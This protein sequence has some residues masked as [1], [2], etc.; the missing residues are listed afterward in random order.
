MYETSNS[1]RS[2]APLSP[3]K[4]PAKKPVLV[5]ASCIGL[6][7]ADAA[8]AQ[9]QVQIYGLMDL[10]YTR[11]SNQG[12]QSV[13]KI[14]SG[15]LQGSR[16]GFRGTEELGGGNQAFFVLEAGFNADNGTLLA[17]NVLF[18]RDSRVGLSGPWGS[19]AA[20]RQSPAMVDYIWRFSSVG[21][22][23]GP[24]LFST[25]PGNYDR[26]LNLAGD[27]SVK[28]ST[29]NLAGFTGSAQYF[30][31]EQAAGSPSL[32]GVSAGAGYEN[33]P[34]AVGGGYFKQ[35]GPI[36]VTAFLAPAANPFT[37]SNPT[38]SLTSYALGASYAIGPAVIHVLATQAKF[39]TAANKARTYEVGGKLAPAGTAWTFGA[40][41]STTD[42]TN[43][44][45]RLNLLTVSASYALSKRTDLYSIFS[46]EKVSGTNVGGTPLVA[47]IFTQG[48]SSSGSQN[49]FQL[50]IRHKF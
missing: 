34:F 6:L 1:I 41:Y 12:G 32:K 25:H 39:E 19:V 18:S 21:A 10:G 26:S 28:Y 3:G 49:A 7:A 17:P 40:D 30:F 15:Q 36:S 23:Y 13:S 22:V 33:G 35:N 2:F 14:S 29:P 27:N 50:G 5:L 38:D 43:R 48:A 45:A 42:V 20:G 31:G 4:K 47:Q 44:D 8:F 16:F 11:V 9:S 24:G 37:T 46:N